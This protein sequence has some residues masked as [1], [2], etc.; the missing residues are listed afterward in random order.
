M[1]REEKEEGQKVEM[2]GEERG[3]FVTSSTNIYSGQRGKEG[4]EGEG[5]G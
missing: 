2:G 3:K 5:R 1:R 4:G